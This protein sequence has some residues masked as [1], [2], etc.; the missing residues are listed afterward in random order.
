MAR[1]QYS[2][3]SVLDIKLKLETQAKQNFASA[4]GALEEEQK[5]LEALY[6]RKSEYEMKAKKLL[7]GTLQIREIEETKTAILVL[8]GYL[9]EQTRQVE[10]AVK[11]LEEARIQLSLA[12]QERKTFE[13][14]REQAFEV[15]LQEENKEESKAVDE[16]VSYSYGQKRQESE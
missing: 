5:K 1:F 8:D 15:F 9:S 14:L 12:M 13:T 3:Q 7:A 10:L 2:L 11:K 4:Q 6:K 16:L